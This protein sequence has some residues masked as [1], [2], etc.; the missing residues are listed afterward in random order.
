MGNRIVFSEIPPDTGWEWT[1]CFLVEG[2]TANLPLDLWPPLLVFSIFLQTVKYLLCKLCVSF[3]GPH[4]LSV[5][6]RATG[7]GGLVL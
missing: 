3:I 7:L 4:E 6:N 5:S 2:C 1:A